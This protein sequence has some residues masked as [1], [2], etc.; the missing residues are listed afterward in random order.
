MVRI[1]WD[2]FDTPAEVVTVLE[3]GQL[4]V[5]RTRE[6]WLPATLRGQGGGA[7]WHWFELLE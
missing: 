6:Y 3:A 1:G 7:I 5:E 4:G 2:L